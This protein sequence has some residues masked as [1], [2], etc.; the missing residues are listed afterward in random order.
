MYLQTGQHTGT[1]VRCRG[2]VA[3]ALSCGCRSA[4]AAAV[5]HLSAFPIVEVSISHRGTCRLCWLLLHGSLISTISGDWEMSPCCKLGG[6]PANLGS[7]SCW[8]LWQH[9]GGVVHWGQEHDHLSH[10]KT[11]PKL[12]DAVTGQVFGLFFCS[13]FFLI[14]PGAVT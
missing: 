10:G 4:R 12:L 1:S 14:G 13:F 11:G 2:F 9:G 5:V 3:L 7:C 8:E 6:K